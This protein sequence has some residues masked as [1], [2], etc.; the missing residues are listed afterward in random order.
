LPHLQGTFFQTGSAH[1]V[2]LH[3]AKCPTAPLKE[4]STLLPNKELQTNQVIYK[5]QLETIMPWFR[6]MFRQGKPWYEREIA[7]MH[8]SL[9]RKTECGNHGPVN[10]GDSCEKDAQM[11]HPNETIL[12]HTFV[13]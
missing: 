4:L 11:V 8:V 1:Y 10:T 5:A 6:C 13:L 7:Q 12:M 2:F 3:I 9:G